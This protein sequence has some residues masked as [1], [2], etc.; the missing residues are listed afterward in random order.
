MHMTRHEASLLARGV[1]DIIGNVNG[2]EVAICPPFT[3]LDTVERLLKGSF[4]KLGAQNCFWEEKGAYT[5]EI[6]PSMLKDLGCS[7]VIL[8]HSE[9]RQFFNET[10]DC[11]NQ[12]IRAVLDFGMAPILCVGETLKERDEGKTKDI[13]AAQ[14]CN[15]LRNI[16][17]GDLR[18]IVVAYE[19][20]WAIGTGKNE[21]PSGANETIK[22][23]R[24]NL[25]DLAGFETANYIRILYGG[26]VKA[27]NIALFMAESEIDGALVGG[28]SLLVDQ[29]VKIINWEK[30]G[31]NV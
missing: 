18:K 9:R 29:F 28:A 20:V 23:L 14:L 7:Y 15:A 6:S 31:A 24:D 11:I 26:S 17:K 16:P 22:F 1:K 4:I 10:D 13:V 2:R 8:G 25:V 5:G 19:P 21:T 12:K 27:D 30:T 3:A